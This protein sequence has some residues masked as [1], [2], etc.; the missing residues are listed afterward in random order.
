MNFKLQWQFQIVLSPLKTGKFT[1]SLST[2]IG[3]RGGP[4]F[5]THCLSLL[6]WPWTHPIYSSSWVLPMRPPPTLTSLSRAMYHRTLPVPLGTQG[7]I[8]G[9]PI[10]WKQLCPGESLHKPAWLMGMLVGLAKDLP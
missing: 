10:S 2:V 6:L 4:W 1:F 9:L 5:R 3:L 7:Y 8:L